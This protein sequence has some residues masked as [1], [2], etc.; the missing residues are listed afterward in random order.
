MATFSPQSNAVRVAP[1]PTSDCQ[2]TCY[3]V[4]HIPIRAQI[5]ESLGADTPAS[6]DICQLGRLLSFDASRLSTTEVLAAALATRV[7]DHQHQCSSTP[8]SAPRSGRERIRLCSAQASCISCRP[9]RG[10]ATSGPSSSPSSPGLRV[11]N[12]AATSSH[13]SHMSCPASHNRIMA[14]AASLH[15]LIRQSSSSSR[16]YNPGWLSHRCSRHTCIHARSSERGSSSEGR[17]ST[18]IRAAHA[19]TQGSASSRESSGS[20]QSSINQRCA[21][22]CPSLAAGKRFR[23]SLGRATYCGHESRSVDLALPLARSMVP[24][25]N[26]PIWSPAA[27]VVQ[28]AYCRTP[29]C[30][31]LAD[32]ACDNVRRRGSQTGLLPLRSARPAGPANADGGPAPMLTPNHP[33]VTDHERT[34]TGN[35]WPHFR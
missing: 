24:P 1:A 25:S 26:H 27:P 28:L 34:A 10:S 8:S 14:S 11:R 13:A 19:G 16:S 20:V 15:R 9:K 23:I 17:Q 4:W 18:Q 29:P 2:A 12:L 21:S 3:G 7:P 6:I 30:L 33:G 31:G 22:A 35:D 5:A 32:E